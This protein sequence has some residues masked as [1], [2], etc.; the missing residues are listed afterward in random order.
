MCIRDRRKELLQKN[1][2][3]FYLLGNENG[4]YM[5]MDGAVMDLIFSELVRY[6]SR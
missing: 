4:Q 5:M 1:L 2:L 6:P 3:D